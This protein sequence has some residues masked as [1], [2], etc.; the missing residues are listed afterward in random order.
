MLT[1]SCS[2]PAYWEERWDGGCRMRRLF[3]FVLNFFLDAWVVC[4]VVVIGRWLI[5]KTSRWLNLVLNTSFLS[6]LPCRVYS[7][8]YGRWSGVNLKRSAPLQIFLL[9][10]LLSSHGWFQCGWSGCLSRILIFTHPGYRIPDPKTATTK[11]GVKKNCHNFLCSHK[12][13]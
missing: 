7:V 5:Q 10:L 4:K 8:F 6:F 11:K 3:L 9:T 12:F 13:H 1:F 2:G